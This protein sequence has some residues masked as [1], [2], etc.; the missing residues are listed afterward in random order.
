VLAPPR[1]GTTLLRVML[2]G[3]PQLFAPPELELLTFATL[4]ERK[5]AFSGRDSFWLEG[6]LR[7]LMEVHRVGAAEAQRLMADYEARGWTTRQFYLQLQDWL[8]G[9]W[10]VDKTPSYALEPHVLRRMEDDFEGARYLHLLRH[11]CA[12]VRSFEEARLERLFFRRPHPFTPRQLAEL[13][14]TVSH[15]NI[16]EFL[17]GVPAGRQLRVRFEDLVREPEPVLRATCAFLGLDFHPAM[18]RPYE[19][20]KG[21]MTDGIHAES[22]MLGDV[23]FHEHRGIDAAAADRWKESEAADLGDVTWQTAEALGYERPAPEA[24]P[25]DPRYRSVLV[26]L[27]GHGPRPPFFCVHP[28]GGSV[29]PFGLLAL[30][31]G[32]DQPFYGLQARGLYN[33]EEPHTRLEEMAAHY[34]EAMRGLQPEGPYLVGGWSLGGIVALEIAQQFHAR[35]HE[36]GLLAILDSPIFSELFLPLEGRKLRPEEFTEVKGLARRAARRGLSM[37]HVLQFSQA[38]QEEL[39]LEDVRRA[40]LVGP[41]VTQARFRRWQEI[42]TSNYQALMGYQVRPYPGT[43]TLFRAT[44]NDLGRLPDWGPDLRWGSVA[45]R[46]EVELIP[47]D[48]KGILREPNVRVL[49]ERLRARL[50]RA[51]AARGARR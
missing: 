35:G 13:V 3:H 50:D 20:R 36:V 21:R 44:G 32:A 48:H 22:R 37:N 5:A 26:R 16:A 6:T 38:D 25:V 42:V 39:M 31:V 46:L 49:A 10:L 15:Q 23:K 41:D 14:W 27:Q 45:G 43:V 40:N 19:D 34:A 12:V 28:L 18:L 30:H 17:E 47:G 51:Q 29:F 9:R 2:G 4:E 1:S 8:G 33:N 7:A 11:P 24:E